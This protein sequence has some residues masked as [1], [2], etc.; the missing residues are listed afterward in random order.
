MLFTARF[1]LPANP[2]TFIA[3]R[4]LGLLGSRPDTLSLGWLCA[5]IH[6]IL[7]PLTGAGIAS[8][9]PALFL[10]GNGNLASA[11]YIR[12]TFAITECACRDHQRPPAS[13][14]RE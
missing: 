8:N 4:N 9:T 6:H 7:F 11:S 12:Y 10:D 3:S 1:W 2:L 5:N 14:C 13:H